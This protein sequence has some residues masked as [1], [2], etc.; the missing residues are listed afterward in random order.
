VR[1]FSTALKIVK[2]LCIF[3]KR[4]VFLEV[5]NCHYT[6]T[7]KFAKV[8]HLSEGERERDREDKLLSYSEHNQKALCGAERM[9]GKF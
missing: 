4:N 8:Q 7:Q 6:I 3:H 9:V 2:I 5:R 1:K